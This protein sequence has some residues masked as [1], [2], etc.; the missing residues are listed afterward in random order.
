MGEGREVISSLE[1]EMEKKEALTPESAPPE[2]Q[3]IRHWG[4][5]DAV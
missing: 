1:L 2:C 4:L 5:G 3:A